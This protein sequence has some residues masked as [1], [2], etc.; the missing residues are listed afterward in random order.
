VGM[1]SLK[2]LIF[3]GFG[4]WENAVS[5]RSVPFCDVATL[6]DKAVDNAVDFASKIMELAFLR[7]FRS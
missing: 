3:K 2:I 5:T 7:T 4:A 1:P 6:D